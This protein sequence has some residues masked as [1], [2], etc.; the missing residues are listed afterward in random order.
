M[1]PRRQTHDAL[2]PGEPSA[3]IGDFSNYNAAGRAQGDQ[4]D[5]EDG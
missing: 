2:H 1:D 3:A 4:V 5:K